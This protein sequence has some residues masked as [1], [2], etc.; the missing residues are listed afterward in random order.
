MR[1]D[2]GIMFALPGHP[3]PLHV[4]RDF[5]S[6]PVLTEAAAAVVL[7]GMHLP[8]GAN[9]DEIYVQQ[10]FVAGAELPF[11]TAIWFT[12]ECADGVKMG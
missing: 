4:T 2:D 3:N 7:E 1:D 5:T 10:A 12:P 6:P 8:A 9:R 11:T